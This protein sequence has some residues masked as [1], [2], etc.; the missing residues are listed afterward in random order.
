MR[1]NIVAHQPFP[2]NL[3]FCLKGCWGHEQSRVIHTHTSS[4]RCLVVAS[5]TLQVLRLEAW[6]T[7]TAT[8]DRPRR[9]ANS[10]CSFL[11]LVRL[12]SNSA[13]LPPLILQPSASFSPPSPPPSHHQALGAGEWGGNLER[14]RF[15]SY[16]GQ[17]GGHQPQEKTSHNVYMFAKHIV[18]TEGRLTKGWWPDGCSTTWYT[19]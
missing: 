7:A 15:P 19:L 5:W 6:T 12:L 18:F 16:Q 8:T 2:G 11:L 14:G 1:T 9:L 13:L 17:K 3:I 10:L 4:C